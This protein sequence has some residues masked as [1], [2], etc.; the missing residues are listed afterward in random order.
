MTQPTLIEAVSFRDPN[1]RLHRWR[2]AR[3]SKAKDGRLIVS[4]LADV[5]GRSYGSTT[6]KPGQYFVPTENIVRRQPV[7]SDG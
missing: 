2:F 5:D 4:R 1:G 6:R 7:V 3:V